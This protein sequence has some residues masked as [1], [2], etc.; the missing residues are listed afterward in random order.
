MKARSTAPLSRLSPLRRL[1]VRKPVGRL[2]S[3]FPAKTRPPLP[4]NWAQYK[5][6]TVFDMEG[7]SLA[8]YTSDAWVHALKEFVSSL[9]PQ[10]GS[11]PAHL[12]GS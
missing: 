5:V 3:F 6:D 12:P 7:P 11:F 8:K 2:M 1:S 4:R 10:A 9:Q